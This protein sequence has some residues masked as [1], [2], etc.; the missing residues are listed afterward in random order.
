VFQAIER[1]LSGQYVLGFYPG[2]SARDGLSHHI[3]AGLS[4]GHAKLKIQQ[5]KT[6]Y[7]VEQEQ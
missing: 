7:T 6:S 5:L 4:P 1:D 2:E 3:D